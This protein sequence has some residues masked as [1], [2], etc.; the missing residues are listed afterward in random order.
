[1]SEKDRALDDD[2]GRGDHPRVEGAYS[3]SQ[4]RSA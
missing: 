2:L 3:G 1:M 4:G